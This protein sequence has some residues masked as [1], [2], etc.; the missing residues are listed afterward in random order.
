MRYKAPKAITGHPAVETCTS[1]EATGSDYRHDVWL[2]DGYRFT[3]GRMAGCQ[4][5]FFNSAA[6]FAYANPQP[7]TGGHPD[8]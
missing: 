1:G 4:G 7:A 8:R 5:A 6:D 3:A 2:R